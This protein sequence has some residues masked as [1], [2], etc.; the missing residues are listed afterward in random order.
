MERFWFWLLFIPISG[1]LLGKLYF[2]FSKKT[3]SRLRVAAIAAEALALSLF[4]FPW[5]PSELGG[6]TGF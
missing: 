2:A 4:Y 1:Y 6:A 3:Y 5:L